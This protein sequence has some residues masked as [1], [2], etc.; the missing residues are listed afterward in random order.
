MP[1]LIEAFSRI[2]ADN[3]LLVIVGDLG[4]VFHTHVAEI[5]AA[6][7]ATAMSDRVRMPGFVPDAE[8][9]YL[10]S[11]AHASFNRH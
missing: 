7:A 1:R 11:H 10:Y 4:D 9:V 8:L 6:I 2:A 3:L 5:Q